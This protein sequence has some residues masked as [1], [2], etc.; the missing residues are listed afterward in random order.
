MDSCLKINCSDNL[1]HS[2]KKGHDIN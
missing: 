1:S 2:K